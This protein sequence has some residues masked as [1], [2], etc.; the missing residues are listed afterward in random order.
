MVMMDCCIRPPDRVSACRCGG[1]RDH[2]HE[3]IPLNKGSLRAKHQ[4]QRPSNESKMQKSIDHAH[5]FAG[6][7]LV[8]REYV[9]QSLLKDSTIHID[10]TY[11]FIGVRPLDH[12]YQKEI[13]ASSPLVLAPAE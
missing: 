7:L 8:E 5:R 2:R 13:S 4:W 12:G 1:N 9:F 11:L 10:Q 6:L 3:R